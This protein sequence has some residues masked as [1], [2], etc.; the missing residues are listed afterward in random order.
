MVIVDVTI[1]TRLRECSTSPVWDLSISQASL[2][3]PPHSE[4]LETRNALPA[5]AA[6]HQGMLNIVAIKRSRLIGSFGQSCEMR[7][8]QDGHGLLRSE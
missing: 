5:Q 7:L 4:T 2:V 8:L 1:S 3:H 6:R